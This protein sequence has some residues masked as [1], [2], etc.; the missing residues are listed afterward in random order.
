MGLRTQVRVTRD[1]CLTPRALGP[2]PESPVGSGRP[3][4]P[5]IQAGVARYI[6]STLRGLR[7]S[8][9]LPR[10]VGLHHGP[11]G[12]GPS[13]VGR[14]GHNVGHPR[15]ARVA[16]DSG[17]PPQDIRH[18]PES[19]GTAGRP[20]G[21]WTWARVAKDIGSTSRAL[22]HKRESPG[23]AGQPRGH[24]HP[25]ESRHGQLV[26]PA[27]GRT[28]ARVTRRA[29]HHRGPSGKARVIRDACLTPWALR[30]GPTL[31]RTADRPSR[32]SGNGPSPPGRL[33]DHRTSDPNPRC[34]G[35]LVDPTGPWTRSRVAKD[36]GSTS[37]ALRHE[38][39]SPGTAGQPRRH[40]DRS[41]RCQEQLIDPAG[42]RARA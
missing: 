38:R 12:T 10:T 32:T 7:Y 2:G 15:K 19:P 16:R 35:N 9:E 25:S 18:G 27:G 42:L 23:N 8:P 36:I 13:H 31:P 37:R 33:V 14:L 21:P 5:R 22:G 26:E 41:A 39:V 4:G 30:Q 34:P 3:R 17:S 29:V 40:S 1:S 20:T 11:S 28:M 6:W 24:S